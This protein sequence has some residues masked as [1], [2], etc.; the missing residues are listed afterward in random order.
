VTVK[1]EDGASL[2]GDEW[3]PREGERPAAGVLLLHGL[4]ASRKTWGDFPATLARAGY[5]VL[6]IDLRV[7]GGLSPEAGGDGDPAGAD[8]RPG[9]A[10][11]DLRAGLAWLRAAPGA[12]PSR[13][14]VI[15]A[16]FGGDLACVASGLG[17]TRTSVALSPDRDRAH[18]LSEHRQLHMQSLLLL[19]TSGDPGR[20]AQARR[21]F[22]E[23]RQP[24]D[25]HVFTG[26]SEGG[27]AILAA[28]PEAIG[29]ILD[30]LHRTL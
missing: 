21:L 8:Q 30:W 29:M 12:D 19:A 27:E 28:R 6:A 15:G 17:L 22:L 24:K 16:G 11:I 9:L 7:A 20:E 1:A 26:C 3:L 18:R 25:V 14:G 23:T 10:P 2:A 13:L 5:R 4:G